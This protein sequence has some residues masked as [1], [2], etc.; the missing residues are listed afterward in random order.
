MNTP[1]TLRVR[2]NFLPFAAP[3]VGQEEV[4]AVVE[5]VRSG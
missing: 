4:D 5:C 3:M 2:E 1:K